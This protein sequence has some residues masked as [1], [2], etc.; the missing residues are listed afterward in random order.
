MNR[1]PK[2]PRE[3]LLFGAGDEVLVATDIG[4]GLGGEAIMSGHEAGIPKNVAAW[5]AECS[6]FKPLT[7]AAK[8]FLRIAR[9]K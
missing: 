2:W 8:A 6:H 1:K 9:G 7:P 4:F 3:A 5:L